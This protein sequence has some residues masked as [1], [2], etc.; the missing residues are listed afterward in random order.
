[1]SKCQVV[2]GTYV[3]Y[4]L[5]IHVSPNTAVAPQRFT[6]SHILLYCRGRA[7]TNT[8]SSVFTALGH[9]AGAWPERPLTCVGGGS[10]ASPMPG[11]AWRLSALLRALGCSGQHLALLPSRDPS[12]ALC[13]KRGGDRPSFDLPECVKCGCDRPTWRPPLDLTVT[14][15]SALKIWEIFPRP[16]NRPRDHPTPI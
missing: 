11:T 16:T 8:N 2:R 6:H 12:S 10:G 4:G 1:M 5:S 7:H 13:V 3:L 14:A 15:V 9:P